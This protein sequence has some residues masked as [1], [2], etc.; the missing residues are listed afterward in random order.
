VTDIQPLIGTPARET[1]TADPTPAAVASPRTRRAVLAGLLGG[2]GAWAASAATKISPVDAA[3]GSSLIIGSSSN[4]AGTSS[5]TLTTA[6]SGTALLVTQNGTGTALRGSAVGPGSIAGFFTAQNGTGVSGV[7][8]NNNS[9]GLFA[10]NN[11]VTIGTLGGAIR[12]RGHENHGLIASTANGDAY[13]V[14]AAN[15]GAAGSGAAV[16]G[17]GN[18]NPG[19]LG[20]SGVNNG[21]V[22]VSA[23]NAG[24]RG[25]SGTGYGVRGISPTNDAVRGTSTSGNGVFGQ[26]TSG[27][28]VVGNSVDGVGVSGISTNSYAGSFTGKVA[29]SEYI[30]VTEMTAPTNPGANIA[31]LFV[32]DT[33]GKTELCVIFP[34]GAIQVIKTEA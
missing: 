10:E 12:A 21:V 25:T 29:V 15:T 31:R 22:G 34:T 17:D 2:L 8:G 6:S 11:A 7:T 27:A 3:A 19:L 14:S 32:R 26:T 4:N 18:N 13:G 16:F 1:I 24:V 28:G 33:G 20:T 30:D 9:F 23:S 5:T